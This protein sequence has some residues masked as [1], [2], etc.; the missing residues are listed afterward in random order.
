[1][2]SLTYAALCLA[3]LT[4]SALAPFHLPKGNLELKSYP[5]VSAAEFA[6]VREGALSLAAEDAALGAGRFEASYF[7]L[8]C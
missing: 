1:M 5:K 6:V 2:K 3:A 7:E 8:T 4:G